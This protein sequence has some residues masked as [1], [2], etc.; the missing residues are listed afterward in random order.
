MSFLA[1]G[2]TNVVGQGVGLSKSA[3]LLQQL[4]GQASRVQIINPALGTVLQF[5]ACINEQ[6]GREAQVTT[7]PLES[8]SVVS[9]HIIVSPLNLALTGVISDTPLYDGKRF[10]TQ[11]I[12]NAATSFLPPLGVAAATT[13]YQLTNPQDAVFSRSS[14][15]YRTLMRLA[16][17]DP[18]ASP[19]QLPAPVTVLT[20]YARY[21]D[22]VIKSL[23]FPRDAS[24]SGQCVF[25]LQLEQI[26]TVS[27]QVVSVQVL[28]DPQLGGAKQTMG[29]QETKQSQ[30]MA[31]YN[32]GSAF[33]S[34]VS[35]ATVTPALNA[36]GSVADGVSHVY[37]N[38]AKVANFFGG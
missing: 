24:T 16:A 1:G 13:A 11:T 22:M 20:K 27:P 19:P 25:T 38:M 33:G 36:V 15:A 18:S 34:D 12:G 28:K 4:T 23:S 30:L 7:S 14:E 32:K 8:G 35:D 3:G 2:I 37:G 31:S 6:H 26:Q 21:T 9:D 10:L 29:E 17:G 5:D